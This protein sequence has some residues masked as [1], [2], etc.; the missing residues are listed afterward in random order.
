MILMKVNLKYPIQKDEFCFLDVTN[1]EGSVTAEEN[2]NH[3]GMHKQ[4]IISS[5]KIPLLP[6]KSFLT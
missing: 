6:R 2:V 4:I 3:D 1:N 5:L